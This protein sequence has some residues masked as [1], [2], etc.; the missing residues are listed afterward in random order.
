VPNRIP[1]PRAGAVAAVS[2][3]AVAAA[4]VATAAYADPLVLAAKPVPLNAADAN[5]TRVGRFDYRGGVQ[6][7]SAD[8]RFGGLS[9]LRVSADG[10]RF[11]AVSDEG[12]LVT[13]RLLYDGAGALAG[14]ADAAISPLRS[15]EGKPLPSL[16]KAASDAESLVLEP[17]GSMLVGFERLHRIMRYPPDGG[18]PSAVT[19]PEGLDRAPSNAGLEALTKLAD[20]RLLALTEGLKADDGVVGWVGGPAA[21]RALIW[22]TDEGFN[23]SDAA[24]LPDADVLVLERRA[25]PPGVRVRLLRAADITPGAVLGGAE[26]ARLEGTLTF[27][28]MEGIAVRRDERRRTLVYIV[29]DD[30]F[31]PLQRTLLLVFRLTD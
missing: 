29:S 26:I 11:V 31:S 30:N 25:F 17:N 3:A 16:G 14:V 6:L 9:G 10:T 12:W 23:V 8:P 18:P 22:R 7:S 27:D 5:V 19:P 13:G 2:T 21:W 28:N 1:R 20:G 15:R 4:I 24:T